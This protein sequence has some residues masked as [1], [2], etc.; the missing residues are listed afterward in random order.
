MGGGVGMFDLGNDGR[1][2]IFFTN[3]AKLPELKKTGAQFHTCLLRNNGGGEFED[4]TRK[5]GLAGEELGYNF[6][7]A[8]GDFNNDGHED[9]FI[10][11]AGHNTLYRNNGDG[12]FT[13][14]TA[15]SRLTKPKDTM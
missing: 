4:G 11:S 10:C 8:V 3:G 2:D 6:G 5:A 7:V 13:D 14:I 1:M 9:L 12:T 15:Q